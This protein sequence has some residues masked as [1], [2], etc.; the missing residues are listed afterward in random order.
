MTSP[1]PYRPALPVDH[2]LVEVAACA[3]SQFDP[4]VAELF[5]D[6]W[7]EQAELWPAAVAS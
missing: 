4:R 7:S 3:G 5:L 6:V 1:R 2:A